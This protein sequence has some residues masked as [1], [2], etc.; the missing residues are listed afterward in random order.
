[1]LPARVTLDAVLSDKPLHALADSTQIGQVVM[2]L[3]TNAWQ[4]LHSGS[5]RISVGLDEVTLKPEVGR[6]MGGLP[7]GSYVH[8]WVSDEGVGIDSEALRRIFEP[9]YTTKPAGQGTGLGLSVVHGIVRAH[10]GGLVV[11][12]KPGDGSTFHV[13]LPQV[14]PDA[15]PTDAPPEPSPAKPGQG[16]RVLYV[17]DDDLMNVMVEQLLTREGY[18]VSC[19]R[20]PMAALNYLRSA[21]DE[22]DIVVSDY[23]MP[24]CSGLE[25][26]Q[27]V[28]AIRP[29]LPVVISSGYVTDE[30]QAEARKLGVRALLQKQ[31]TLE[32]MPTLIH[33][34]LSETSQSTRA[35]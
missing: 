29:T 22:V 11:E 2:N 25:V 23:N 9:F 4:A 18:R 34:V 17:D 21:P 12:S 32:E 26:A 30:L 33:R 19:H 6:Q 31:N 8:L 10:H 3:C 15:G 28:V 14:R 27:E 16:Q 13:Y 24:V 20:D 7:G 35:E 1:M 5:G